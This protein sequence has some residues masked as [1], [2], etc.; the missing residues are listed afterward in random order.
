MPV[1]YH[2]G[3][4]VVEASDGIRPIRTI[5]TAV[6]GIVATAS[7]ADAVAF[8]L[9]TPVLVTSINAAIGKAGLLGTLKPTLEAIA[10][11]GNAMC[12]IVCTPISPLGSCLSGWFATGI[13][14]S[15]STSGVSAGGG[16][17]TAIR[18]FLT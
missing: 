4:R 12:V 1:D 6:I 7:D 10:A 17:G 5:S 15:P 16:F 2:H 3:V 18:E 14:R 13:R 9:D 8:P 11:E